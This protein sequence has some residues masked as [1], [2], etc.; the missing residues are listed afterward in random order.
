MASMYP[1]WDPRSQLGQRFNAG[2]GYEILLVL[3]TQAVAIA[4]GTQAG[5]LFFNRV[6]AIPSSKTTPCADTLSQVIVMGRSPAG[7]P[8]NNQ[9]IFDARYK[10]LEIA[11]MALRLEPEKAKE[12]R[13]RY[14]RG[15]PG[16][17]SPQ[18]WLAIELWQCPVCVSHNPSGTLI[19]LCCESHCL[20][21]YMSR[22]A[23]VLYASRVRLV[24]MQPFS[25]F[26]LKRESA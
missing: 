25:N 13:S 17:D 21:Q 26:W 7:R 5:A 20:C 23:H 22:N 3:D 4:V 16:L 1:N 18:N 8:S 14:V 19:C 12:H 11:A 9:I 6:G 24:N 15:Y 10:G 2:L